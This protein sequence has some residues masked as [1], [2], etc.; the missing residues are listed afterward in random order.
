MTVL[1]TAAKAG[2]TTTTIEVPVR[3]GPVPSFANTSAAQLVSTGPDGAA[4]VGYPITLDGALAM[5]PKPA[6]GVYSYQWS[7]SA[8]YAGPFTAI[9]GATTTSYTPVAL[10]VNKYVSV[11]ITLKATGRALPTAP[12]WR[13][14]FGTTT[15]PAQLF[16]APD[17]LITGGSTVGSTLT[18]VPGTW[19]PAP[20]TF[21]YQWL[22]NAVAIPGATKATYV[23]AAADN[24]KNITVRVTGSKSGLVSRAIVSPDAI[25]VTGAVPFDTELPTITGDP[26]V[27]QMLTAT[28]G[29]WTPAPTTFTYQWFRGTTPISG[30][31]KATYVVAAADNGKVLTVRTTGIK[32]GLPNAFSEAFVTIGAALPTTIVTAPSIGTV[33]R[34]GVKLTATSGSW[35]LP[36]TSYLYQLVPQ[37]GSDRRGDRLLLHADHRR[38]G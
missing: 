18:V 31:T 8:A 35:L 38:R 5:D 33:A 29:A 21:A 27:G 36:P 3:L 17:P 13:V 1:I 32:A 4:Q 6:N 2:Y 26:N 22:R 12:Q 30:A 11:A 7:R 24:G 28:P 34:V 9:A 14:V 19:D 16:T 25:P 20:T 37:R 23:L 10:D 15:Q